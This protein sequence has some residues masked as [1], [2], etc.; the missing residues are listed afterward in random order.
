MIF[1]LKNSSP[2]LYMSL[3][4]MYRSSGD[5][6]SHLKSHS[7]SCPSN[8]SLFTGLLPIWIQK[9]SY[10][11]FTYIELLTGFLQAN[12]RSKIFYRQKI[13]YRR[14]TDRRP[15]NCPLKI[16]NKYRTFSNRRY[17]MLPQIS[18]R[19]FEVR[20]FL[21]V[22]KNQYSKKPLLEI[23]NLLQAFLRLRISADLQQ[24]EGLLWLN[25]LVWARS[26]SCILTGG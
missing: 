20:D 9:T 17:Y 18:Y 1:S 15:Y 8:R 22:I 26:I 5:R 2:H 25:R 12:Y 21:Q 16:T 7:S 19:P 23:D 13:F 4:A 6:L 10:S 14:S 3:I 24:I 11:S